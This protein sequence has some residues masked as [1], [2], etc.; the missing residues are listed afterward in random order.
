MR[1]RGAS[2][3]GLTTQTFPSPRGCCDV[4]YGWDVDVCR[5]RF[6]RPRN[7][8]GYVWMKDHALASLLSQILRFKTE[9]EAKAYL[10][11]VGADYH[12][13]CARIV[14]RLTWKRTLSQNALLH[15]WFG[16][17][18]KHLGDRSAQDVKGECHRDIGLTI[19]LRDEQFGWVW[20]QTGRKM[21]AEQQAKLLASGCLNLSSG[22]SVKELRE[23]MDEIERVYSG[24]NLTR[25]E[26]D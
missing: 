13:L 20:N 11:N 19:R 6:D 25:P 24:V 12:D 14:N 10:A 1:H 4:S 16:E 8:A 21:N 2:L 26:A 15:V 18:A 5:W 22:M 9:G 17:I 7:W 3:R 23:Y